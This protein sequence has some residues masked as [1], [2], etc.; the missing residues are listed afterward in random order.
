MKKKKIKDF[1]RWSFT[2]PSLLSQQQQQKMKSNEISD[3]IIEWATFFSDRSQLQREQMAKWPQ[4]PASFSILYIYIY[5]CFNI[6]F[7]Y[8]QVHFNFILLGKKIEFITVMT[9]MIGRKEAKIVMVLKLLAR[10]RFDSFPPPP[11]PF[12]SICSICSICSFRS[13][14]SIAKKMGKCVFFFF[15]KRRVASAI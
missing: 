3:E 14:C 9:A 1:S 4:L 15:R 2:S 5:I 11:P 6:L 8:C 13:I 12:Y 7:L 10:G